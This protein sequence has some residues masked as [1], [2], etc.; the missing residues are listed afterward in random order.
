MIIIRQ[1]IYTD[2]VSRQQAK[3]AL[4]KVGPRPVKNMEI[5]PLKTRAKIARA[6]RNT[7]NDV[8]D[9]VNNPAGAVADL[10]KN[11]VSRPMNTVG[12]AAIAIPFPA[13]VPAGIACIA[14][15]NKIKEKVKPLRKASDWVKDGIESSGAYKK[16]KG[17][18]LRI[19]KKYPYRDRRKK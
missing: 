3:Q 2:V 16:I 19:I 4:E 6:Y 17:I 9:I 8:V 13:S 1:K 15:G 11:T 18:D 10:G 5:L 7:V 12:K 14:A